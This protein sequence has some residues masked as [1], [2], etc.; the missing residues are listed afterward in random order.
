MNKIHSINL[1]FL[2]IEIY[3]VSK[4]KR[5][6]VLHTMHLGTCNWTTILVLSLMGLGVC[7]WLWISDAFVRKSTDPL[8]VRVWVEVGVVKFYTMTLFVKVNCFP[9]PYFLLRN[10]NWMFHEIILSTLHR[11]ASGSDDL[12]VKCGM[13]WSAT[14]RVCCYRN[15]QPFVLCTQYSCYVKWQLETHEWRH[16]SLCVRMQ[17]ECNGLLYW[18]ES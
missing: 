2:A 16:Q 3:S 14:L 13:C 1:N 4:H 11:P 6:P 5:L 12:E 10:P 8:S 9:A 18:E 17:T 15:G 7:P